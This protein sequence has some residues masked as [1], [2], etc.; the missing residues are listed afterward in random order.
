MEFVPSRNI[1][2]DIRHRKIIGNVCEEQIEALVSCKQGVHTRTTCPNL[3]LK[4]HEKTRAKKK[5]KQP[6]GKKLEKCR[7]ETYKPWQ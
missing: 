4:L 3:Q 2:G 6:K 7:R 5:K 1:V